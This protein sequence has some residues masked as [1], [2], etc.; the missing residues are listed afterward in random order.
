MNCPI[1]SL[2]LP[3]SF[4]D[5]DSAM[6]NNCNTLTSLNVAEGNKTYAS[7]DGVL[8]TADGETLLYYLPTRTDTAYTVPDGTI[9]IAASAFSDNTSLESVTIPASV[10]NIEAN[11][12]SN[13]SSLAEVTIGEGDTVLVIG[14]YAFSSTAIETLDLPSRTTA[15]GNN[16]FSRSLLTSLAFGDNSGLTS[17]GE[18]AFEGTLIEDITLPAGLRSLGELAFSNCSALTRVTLSEGLTSIGDSVFSGCS[19]LETV[20]LPASL[21]TV[22]TMLF[23]NC[24]SLKNVIFADNS[25]IRTLPVNTFYGCSALESITLPASLTEIPGKNGGGQHA[26]FR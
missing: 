17:I 10:G 2:T 14:D 6:L 25:Q 23:A 13:C 20:S 4:D 26:Y 11:A 12:F 3:A 24:T 5:F 15:I 16:A 9:T 8:F 1:V 21:N 18:S 19:A 22:G 7:K